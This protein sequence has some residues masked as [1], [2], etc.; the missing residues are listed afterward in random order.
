MNK[1]IKLVSLTKKDI[2]FLYPK[3]EK[4]YHQN[5][6]FEEDDIY[7]DLLSEEDK[8]LYGVC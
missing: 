4:V 8:K 5:E 2:D 1:T 3:K 6:Y 7:N